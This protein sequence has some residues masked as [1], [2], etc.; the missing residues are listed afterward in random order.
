MELRPVPTS[1][2][3]T[4]VT[5]GSVLARVVLLV[6]GG[7]LQSFDRDLLKVGGKVGR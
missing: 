3:V 5:L 2:L 1:L 7:F 6:V 4:F